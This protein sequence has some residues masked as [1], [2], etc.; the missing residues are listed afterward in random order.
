MMR[1][2]MMTKMGWQADPE[3]AISIYSVPVACENGSVEITVA[4]GGQNIMLCGRV[5]SGFK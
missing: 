2:G 1:V 4:E 3:V 5:P